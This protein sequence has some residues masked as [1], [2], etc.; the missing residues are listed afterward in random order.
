MQ[1]LPAQ[2]KR[3]ET[4]VVQ[5]GEDWPGVFIRGDNAGHYAM[6]AG[7]LGISPY[8]PIFGISAICTRYQKTHDIT[9]HAGIQ[10]TAISLPYSRSLG[11]T[12]GRVGSHRPEPGRFRGLKRLRK[13]LNG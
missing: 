7:M 12:G 9:K 2:E 6:V 8:T 4:G 11:A 1:R 10:K 3:V 5:F 13:H